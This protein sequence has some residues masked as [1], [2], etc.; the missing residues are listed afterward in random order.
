MGWKDIGKRLSARE[1]LGA[2]VE[3]GRARVALAVNVNRLRAEKGLSQEALAAKVG[4]RQPNI[5]EIERGDANPRL[6]TVARLSAALGVTV[7][8]L[9]TEPAA[10]EAS[11]KDDRPIPLRA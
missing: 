8:D 6:D 3:A 11:E 2:E 10:V 7:A 5:S 4:T 1:D 9:Y